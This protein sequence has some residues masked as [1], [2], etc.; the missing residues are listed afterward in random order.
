LF[1]FYGIKYEMSYPIMVVPG[2]PDDRVAALRLAFD[3]TMTDPAYRAD[4]QRMGIALNPVTGVEMRD[5]MTTINDMPDDLIARLRA[6]I[7][8]PS[9]Q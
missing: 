2:V 7:S 1:E 8:T 6:L 5:L 3:Q 9:V 4:A